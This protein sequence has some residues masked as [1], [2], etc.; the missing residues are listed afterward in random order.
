[1]TTTERADPRPKATNAAKTRA[2]GFDRGAFYRLCRMLHAY[3]SAFAFLALMFFSVTGLLLDHP[4][5]LAG[6]GQERESKLVVPTATLA[7]AHAQHDPNAALAAYVAG[8]VPLVGAYRSAEVD[9]G[10]ANLRFEGVKGSST[11]VV[12]LQSGQADVTVEHA[13]ALTVIGDLHRGKNASIAWRAVIDITA[14]LVCVM[15]LIGY[16]LFFSLR[17]RLRTSL[18]LTAAS[19]AVLVAVFVWLTP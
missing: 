16:V 2:S 19:L 1:M 10:Q 17:F 15:S 11:V 4:D 13:T 12:D 8:K 9:D 5:W 18:I 14:V 6:R 7:Q 3:L